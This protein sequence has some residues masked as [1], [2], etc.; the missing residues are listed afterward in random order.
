LLTYPVGRHQVLLG[1]FLRHLFI[2]VMAT[3]VGYGAAG[4]AVGLRVGKNWQKLLL[5]CIRR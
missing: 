4:L 1:K 2:L 5:S 3:V